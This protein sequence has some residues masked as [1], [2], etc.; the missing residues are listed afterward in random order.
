VGDLST[1]ARVAA[2]WSFGDVVARQFVQLSITIV[3]ARLLAP[4]DFALAIATLCISLASVFVDGGLGR[5]LIRRGSL[6]TGRRRRRSGST[7][8]WEL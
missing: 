6:R 3:L 7:S 4:E 1:R 2:L 8:R 5:A